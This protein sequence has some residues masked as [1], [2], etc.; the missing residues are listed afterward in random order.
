MKPRCRSEELSRNI[1]ALCQ[2]CDGDI[3]GQAFL[4]A[5]RELEKSLAELASLRLSRQRRRDVGRRL[6]QLDEQ[7]EDAAR[8]HGWSQAHNSVHETALRLTSA[9]F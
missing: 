4:D 7:Y 8:L 5:E 3:C 6:R 2:K 1:I 9:P